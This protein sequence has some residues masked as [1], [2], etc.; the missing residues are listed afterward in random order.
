MSLSLYE[1]VIALANKFSAAIRGK[2]SLNDL[3]PNYDSGVNYEVGNLVI[4]NGVLQICTGAGTG[5]EAS[6]MPTN[7]GN[8]IA[9]GGAVPTQVNADWDATEGPEKILNKPDAMPYLFKSVVLSGSGATRGCPLSPFKNNQLDLTASG[10]SGI[11]G[12]SIVI[13]PSPVTGAMRDL[14]FVVK[15]G[16]TAPVVEWPDSTSP[17]DDNVDNLTASSDATTIFLVSEYASGGFIVA[18]QV[19]P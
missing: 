9:S 13:S 16:N 11:T 8:A 17:A 18:R 4:R 5:S 14:W 6:W 19:V 15:S 3:A 1:K 2:A 12:L 7:I 10:M